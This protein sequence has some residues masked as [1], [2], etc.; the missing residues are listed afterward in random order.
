MVPNLNFSLIKEM[1]KYSAH[2]YFGGILIHLDA[3]LT[4]LLVVLYLAPDQ[5]AFFSMGK[6]RCEM[7]T[8][9]VPNA[10]GPLLFPRVCI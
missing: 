5:V 8:R 1:T 6:G 10:I 3:Y 7:L 9:I 2:F 4:N